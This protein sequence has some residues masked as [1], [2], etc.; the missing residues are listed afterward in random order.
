[1]A[2]AACSSTIFPAPEGTDSSTLA[3]NLLVLANGLDSPVYATSPDADPR[4]FVLERPGRIRILRGAS[5]A[6]Q[7]F[8]D[9][10]DRVS[11]GDE[12]GLLGLAFDPDFRASGRFFVN[13]TDLDGNTR[14]EAYLD[15]DRGDRADPN[16]GML[17]LKVE[18]PFPSHNG[19]QIEF[20]PGNMLYIAETRSLLSAA[21]ISSRPEIWHY[22]FRNP[23]RFSFDVNGGFMFIADMGET[24]W[25]EINAVP[26]ERGGENFGWSVLEGT[27][28]F[29]TNQ[30]VAEGT[31]FP[32]AVYGRGDGC[33]IAGGYVYRGNAVPALRGRY[34]YSDYCSGWLR[35]FQLQANGIAGDPVELPVESPGNVTSL[36]QDS[37]G[38]LYVLTEDGRVLGIMA[39]N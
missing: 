39:A 21:D 9:I 16:S 22:G 19:G 26:L 23:R 17:F 15:R 18:Q 14:I 32:V 10:T 3:I 35:T 11:F 37:D 5:L 29:A 4:L 27:E 7:P 1:M 30:C 24:R 25:E 13:Y 34:I 38:E 20:G 33:S 2:L 31:R 8:L 12:Q 6:A 36:G 28:C